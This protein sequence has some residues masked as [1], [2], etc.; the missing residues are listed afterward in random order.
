VTLKSVFSLEVWRDHIGT[1]GRMPHEMNRIVIQLRALK[2]RLATG[3]AV[4]RRTKACPKMGLCGSVLSLR[5]LIELNPHQ[6]ALAL[7]AGYA[8]SDLRSEG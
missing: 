5:K 3:L 2:R 7:S 6:P 1:S 8:A 4:L